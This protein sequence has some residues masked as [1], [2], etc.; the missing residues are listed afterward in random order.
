[1]WLDVS[2]TTMRKNRKINMDYI[3]EI[4]SYEQTNLQ[5]YYVVKL[6]D[7]STY[8]VDQNQHDEIMEYFNAKYI[9]THI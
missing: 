9:S 1:M 4:Q 5:G 6:V 7:K 8:V 2:N 3:I